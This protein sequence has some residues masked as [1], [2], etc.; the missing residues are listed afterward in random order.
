[1]QAIGSDSGPIQDGYL[2]Q[3][4]GK[5]GVKREKVLIVHRGPSAG[6]IADAYVIGRRER[7]ARK[8]L[9]PGFWVV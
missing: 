3:V 5:A 2:K 6:G 1:M 7:G 9:T 4:Q 8:R